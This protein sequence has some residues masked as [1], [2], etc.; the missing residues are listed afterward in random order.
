MSVVIGFGDEFGF[1]VVRVY[2]VHLVFQLEVSF[3]HVSV[4]VD[5]GLHFR[6]LRHEKG[7]LERVS[8]TYWLMPE[9]DFSSFCC[10]SAI[11][12]RFS[13]SLAYSILICVCANSISFIRLV[14]MV[15]T[16]SSWVGVGGL[17]GGGDRTGFWEVRG[18]GVV[19]R[20]VGGFGL[21]VGVEARF[22]RSWR[23]LG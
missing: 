23:F 11:F 7:T 13:V 19:S 8:S 15:F 9:C 3:S 16:V 17:G 22:L 1:G 21:G 18:A 6:D 20:D 4:F 14:L 10:S 5:D 12:L 2:F